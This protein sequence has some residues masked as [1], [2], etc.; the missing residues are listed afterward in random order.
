[1]VNSSGDFRQ[2]KDTFVG[3]GDL[4]LDSE[5]DVD[6]DLNAC[7]NGDRDIDLLLD[8]DLVLEHYLLQDLKINLKFYD[9]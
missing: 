6:R 1:M 4:D 8:R 2:P 5:H 9:L 3:V 7:L